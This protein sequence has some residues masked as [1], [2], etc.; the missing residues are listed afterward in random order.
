MASNFSFGLVHVTISEVNEILIL[1]AQTIILF[2]YIPLFG[3]TEDTFRLKC[4][5]TNFFSFL[6]CFYLFFIF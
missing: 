2:L 5:K 3:A 4:F 6:F 1:L